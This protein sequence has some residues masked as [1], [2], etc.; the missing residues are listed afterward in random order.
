MVSEKWSYLI[1]LEVKKKG[2]IIGNFDTLEIFLY[3][4][5]TVEKFY[6]GKKKSKELP[7]SLGKFI[8]KLEEAKEK[9]SYLPQ[10]EDVKKEFG[11]VILLVRETPD[12][13]SRFDE[14]KMLNHITLKKCEVEVYLKEGIP[15][16]KAKEVGEYIKDL[17]SVSEVLLMERIK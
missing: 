11:D 3:D 9:L 2:K 13:S 8:A 12:F 4:G 17:D 15:Y 1:K 10:V 6:K 16:K 14:S 5:G 7:V